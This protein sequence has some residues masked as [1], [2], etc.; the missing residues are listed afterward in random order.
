MTGRAARQATH[1]KAGAQ[2]GGP[3][4]AQRQSGRIAAIAFLSLS[5]YP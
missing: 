2:G 5:R 1:G 3:G 4:N